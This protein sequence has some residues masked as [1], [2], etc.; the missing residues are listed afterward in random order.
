MN[1]DIK[2]FPSDEKWRLTQS[3]IQLKNAQG[4]YKDVENNLYFFHNGVLESIHDQPAIKKSD[5]SLLWYSKGMLHRNNLPA[6]IVGGVQSYYRYDKKHYL[7]GPAILNTIYAL[8]LR[9]YWINDHRLSEEAFHQLPKYLNNKIHSDEIISFH[10]I[11]SLQKK[12][13]SFYCWHG[14]FCDTSDEFLFLKLNN[15]L[16]EKSSISKQKL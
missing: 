5:G 6:K 8:Y 4:W 9:Q 15:D 13:Y 11:S 14:H 1:D 16:S 2:P 7:D 12:I 3:I 10:D